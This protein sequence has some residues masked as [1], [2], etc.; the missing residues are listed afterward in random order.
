[1]SFWRRLYSL[2][3]KQAGLAVDEA[4]WR[5]DETAAELVAMTNQHARAFARANELERV[6]E[7]ERRRIADLDLRI[8]ELTSQ[9]RIA[10]LEIEGLA[11]VNEHLRQE[12]RANLAAAV[13]REDA[14]GSRLASPF[15]VG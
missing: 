6:L 14:V 5:R 15:S 9:H 10:V 4:N 8:G 2:R 1:M 13:G 12:L 3:W 11:L 7:A